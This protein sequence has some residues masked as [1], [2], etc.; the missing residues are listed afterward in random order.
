MTKHI[1]LYLTLQIFTQPALKSW[2]IKAKVKR[3]TLE[4]TILGQYLVKSVIDAS[5]WKYLQY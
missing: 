4:N 3:S 2:E 1:P 5:F